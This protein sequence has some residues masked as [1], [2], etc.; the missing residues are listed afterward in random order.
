MKLKRFAHRGTQYSLPENTYTSIETIIRAGVQAIEADVQLTKE[1]IPVLLHD[2]S[3]LRTHKVN[4]WIH[5][6]TI[7][8]CIQYNIPTLT[9]VLQLC[10]DHSIEFAIEVKPDNP[11]QQ[12][13]ES[14]LHVVA[15]TGAAHLVTL[16]SFDREILQEFSR[17]NPPFPL[18]L[19]I[20]RAPA[21]GLRFALQNGMGLNPSLRC[22]TKSLV[23]ESRAQ[24]VPMHVWT[25]NDD[26]VI[27]ILECWGVEGVIS[28]KLLR[29]NSTDE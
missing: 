21:E 5:E 16:Y 1:K 20:E 24:K 2:Q 8:E 28:D 12:T 26:Q 4:R 25:V 18:H 15:K 9:S 27:A 22:V 11:V 7:D 23:E 14:V 29:E 10:R 3:L 17:Q 6:L 13:I 19:N